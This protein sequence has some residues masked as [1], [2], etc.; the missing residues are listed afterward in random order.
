MFQ[1]QRLSIFEPVP[2][3]GNTFDNPVFLQGITQ[4]DDS[5]LYMDI[6]NRQE[7]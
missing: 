5:G 3:G 4:F 1:P 2:P 6:Q 7:E